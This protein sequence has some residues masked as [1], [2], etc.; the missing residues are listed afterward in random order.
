MK[1]LVGLLRVLDNPW[2]E[3]AWFRILQLLE[4]VGPATARRVMDG[5]GVCDHDGTDPGAPTPLARLLAA[6]PAVPTSA[7]AQLAGLRGALEDCA[8]AGA[9][10]EPPVATQ[11]DRLLKWLEPVI[12]V[13]YDSPATRCGDLERLAEPG[14][15]GHQPRGLRGRPDPRPTGV[16]GGSGR[17]SVA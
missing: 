14:R 5:L 4:G 16:V 7:A 9:E 1:D 8:G 17:T 3:L 2:D 13:R 12:L 11:I 6:P 10:S 15:R